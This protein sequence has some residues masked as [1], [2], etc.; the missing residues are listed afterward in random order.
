MHLQSVIQTKPRVTYR[1]DPDFKNKV[2]PKNHQYL[3]APWL[4][5]VSSPLRVCTNATKPSVRPVALCDMDR[6]NSWLRRKPIKST[7][8][9]TANQTIKKKDWCFIEEGKDKYSAPRHFLEFH[10]KST[11]GLCVRIVKGMPRGLPEV[12][13]CQWENYQQF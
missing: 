8:S 10:N 2:A 4:N 7:I 11:F 13:F 6:N 5:Y 1:R 3:I 9:I 12:E